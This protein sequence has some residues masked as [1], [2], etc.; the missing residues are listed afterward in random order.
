[1]NKNVKKIAVVGAGTAGLICAMILK[2]RL[3]VDI[4]VIYS[5]NFGIIGVGEGSTEHFN[6][7]M[8]FLG[9]SQ[10]EIIAECDATYKVG[11]MFDGW[12]SD[13]KQKYL[14]SVYTEFTQ[15][16]GLYMF[17]NAK[18]IIDG[19]SLT[20]DDTFNNV[21]FEKNTQNERPE[22]I[23]QYH[24][25]THKLND[26]LMKK[27]KQMGINFID[28]DIQ[29]VSLNENGEISTLIGTKDKYS[30][31]DFFIDSTGLKRIL[32][33]KL[34]A[35]WNSYSKYLMLNSAI[36]FPTEDEDDY[37]LWTLA[38]AMKS[39]WMFRIPVW[40]RYGN[41]YIYDKNHI[42]RD[43][44]KKEVDEYFGRDIEIKKEFSFDPGALEEVWIKN[45]CAVGLS[46]SFVEPLEATSIGTTIQQSFILA[47]RLASYSDKDIE[48][49]NRSF[50][51]IMENI[52]DY[53]IL[54]YL[55]DRKDSEFWKKATTVE[56]PEKLEYILDVWKY[57][58]PTNED[59]IYNTTY[60]L[61]KKE[62]FIQILYG[63]NKFDTKSLKNEYNSY[64]E[65]MI[66]YN[67]SLMN[68]IYSR[69]YNRSGKISHKKYIGIIREQMQ[70][71]QT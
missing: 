4:D 56:L 31:Y 42:T 68:D 41:G 17:T 55:S 71:T 65:D 53:I 32:M 36:T 11:I 51:A 10:R 52:R 66:Q 16:A 19:E 45:C 15:A 43:D 6:E 58:V 38:K 69:N 2:R 67:L 12:T 21:L 13:P 7:F 60:T 40:G 3:N 63:L 27:S 23:N 59:L 44:A 61:F 70:N 35:K 62:N 30:S 46:G 64:S 28:D 26:F 8:L 24:F 22:E 9:I 39:G 5:S 18:R 57:R 14:H 33:T 37:N 25:N 50:S 54:H 20:Y 34:G 49:Y 29:D 1:M 47:N 48:L